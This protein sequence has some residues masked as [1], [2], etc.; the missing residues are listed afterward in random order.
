MNKPS[1]TRIVIPMTIVV[2]AGFTIKVLPLKAQGV[3][4]AGLVG[5][6]GQLAVGFVLSLPDDIAI[7]VGD[8]LG[9]AQVIQVVVV[10]LVIF[11]QG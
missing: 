9:G 1:N 10:D 4:Y 5:E 11:D 3:G 8:F 6:A 2:Q 7:V